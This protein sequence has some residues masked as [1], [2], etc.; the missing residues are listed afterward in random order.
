V[1][2]HGGQDVDRGFLACALS[3]QTKSTFD[4]IRADVK[5]TFRANRSSLATTRV[6]LDLV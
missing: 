2:G 6:A 3:Q 1:L 5:A 4:S